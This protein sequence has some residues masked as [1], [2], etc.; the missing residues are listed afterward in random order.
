MFL[1]S[2]CRSS[3]EELCNPSRET[4]KPK[5]AFLTCK[6]EDKSACAHHSGI[7]QVTFG[8]LSHHQQ[9]LKG[10]GMFI[11]NSSIFHNDKPERM[12][13][14]TAAHQAAAPPA[15]NSTELH[16]PKHFASNSSQHEILNLLCRKKKKEKKKAMLKDRRY[17]SYLIWGFLNLL[18]ANPFGSSSF[19]QPPQ[20]VSSIKN[21]KNDSYFS[22]LIS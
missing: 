5:F 1:R 9:Y 3:W 16:L 10:S 15:Q 7:A 17:I 19:L 21:L 2:S 13:Q 11:L 6:A 12:S 14:S 8:S 18:G 20:N 22:I 4:A